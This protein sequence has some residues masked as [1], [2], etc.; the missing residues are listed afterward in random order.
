ML[1]IT[2]HFNIGTA[3]GWT[4]PSTGYTFRF[5]DKFSDKL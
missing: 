1:Q 2:I 3:G 5:I 4:K